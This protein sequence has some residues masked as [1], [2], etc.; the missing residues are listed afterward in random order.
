MSNRMIKNV[1]T[2]HRRALSVFGEEV[3]LVMLGVAAD[4]RS[5]AIPPERYDQGS[6]CGTACCIAGH[7]AFRLN[8]KFD[9]ADW[10]EEYEDKDSALSES[11]GGLFANDYGGSPE[12]AADAIERYVY[13][14]S[15]HPWVET[16]VTRLWPEREAP[17]QVCESRAAVRRG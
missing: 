9:G 11:Y 12:K 16:E 4:F 2:I 6:Y 13:D 3:C 7:V 1:R 8:P 14:G 17:G 10:A 5:G 15:D